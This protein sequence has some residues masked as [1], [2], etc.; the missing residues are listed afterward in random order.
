V[1]GTY[2]ASHYSGATQTLLVVLHTM[3]HKQCKFGR[4]PAVTNGTILLRPK[5]SPQ[6]PSFNC[7]CTSET[8]HVA[9]PSHALQLYQVRSKLGSNEG[10]FTLDAE[11]GFRPYLASHCSGLTLTSEMMHPHHAPQ[12]VQDWSKSGNKEE[13]F[14]LGAETI[15]V[16]FSPRIAPG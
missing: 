3:P 2:H 6:C 5:V 10:Q 14:T 8:S 1:F 9:I 15:F 12:P 7:S 16:P 4:N 11:T 13:N